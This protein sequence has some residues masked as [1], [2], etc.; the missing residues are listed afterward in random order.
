MRRRVRGQPNGKANFGFVQI[1]QFAVV[2]GED[3]LQFKAGNL[4]FHGASYDDGSLVIFR[5][6]GAVQGHQ[7]HINGTG[8]YKFAFDPRGIV[9]V[10]GGGGADGFRIKITNTSGGVVYDNRPAAASDA[11]TS[12]NTQTISGGSVTIH[13]K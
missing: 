12:A 6:H 10:S 2:N 5:T 9:Q 4:N 7:H 1:Q 11:M 3:G 8:T 13:S